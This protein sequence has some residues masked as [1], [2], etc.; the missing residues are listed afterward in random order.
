LQI[1]P[2]NKTQVDA[3]TREL[4]SRLMS[5][6]MRHH[7]RTICGAI[8]CMVVVAGSTIAFAKLIEPIL[9]GVFDNQN[10]N[11]IIPIA[12]VLVAIGVCRGFA[13]FGQNMLMARASLSIV[14]D[15]QAEVFAHLMR[16]DLAF[17]QN[18]ATGRLQS[19]ISNDVGVIQGALANTLVVAGRDSITLTG[20]IGLMLY[21]DWLM[22]M[23]GLLGLPAVGFGIYRIGTRVRRLSR[24]Q[25]EQ[26]SKLMTMLDEAFRGARH[27]K[28]YGM[29]AH[30]TRLATKQLT[31]IYRLAM[32][33]VKT[34]AII[35][36][37]VEV[38]VGIGMAGGVIYGGY[39]VI[40]GAKTTGAFFS[41][42]TA[43]ILCYGPIRRLTQF[44]AQLQNGLAAAQR[45][46]ALLD[47][48]PTIIDRPDAPALVLGEGEIRFEDV[49]F[50]YVENM[51]ALEGISL[52]IPAG[53][54]VALVGPSGAGKSTILN[55]I[56]RFYDVDSGAITIN[57]QDVRD[58]TL[59]SLRGAIGLVS[60]EI[61][62]FDDTVRANIG[63]GK[64]DASDDEIIAAAKRAGAHDFIAEL[65]AGY[66]TIV[67]G[68]GELLSG[69][70]RQRIAIARAILKNAPVLLLDE[71]T[72]SLDTT[73]ERQIQTALAELMAGR[74]TL[75]IAHRL[76]TIVNADLIHVVD[77]GR[78]VESG[79]HAELLAHDSHYAR[80]QSVQAEAT[81]IDAAP[82][83]R[84]RA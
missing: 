33:L 69:G 78:I 39:Q 46:F 53:R 71:A 77:H 9:D 8:A 82:A 24:A 49:R 47:T 26:R 45:V 63:Y 36:P 51:P 52:S 56:L 27:V 48:E 58:V 61:S 75:V 72:S 6:Y 70:Q 22:A 17:F 18:M 30:E 79:T 11:V 10:E 64:P 23:I 12:L 62:L 74:T 73:S 59:A 54:T 38:F 60:Q 65:P 4:L 43:L 5:V 66:D 34:R 21:Q 50:S 41:L 13:T 15:I 68:R 81:E 80:L 1:D 84:A 29:E 35:Y 31:E 2:L 20:L 7:V 44:N 14:R 67:G 28:S 19:R 37:A 57:G 16:A 40:D 83:T 55:L 42:I 25:Q 3:S 76:S 32:K